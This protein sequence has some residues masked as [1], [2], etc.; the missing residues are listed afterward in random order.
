[1]RVHVVR[2]PKFVGALLLGLI[3][4]FGGRGARQVQPMDSEE[5]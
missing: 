1:V 5:P 4:L 3:S 2:V